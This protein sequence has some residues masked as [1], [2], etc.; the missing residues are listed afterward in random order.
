MHAR[1]AHMPHSPGRASLALRRAP[2]DLRRCR[3]HTRTCVTASCMAMEL[4]STVCMSGDAAP[5]GPPAAAARAAFC[6]A[7]QSTSS[8]SHSPTAPAAAALLLLLL[9]AVLAAAAGPFDGPGGGGLADLEEG[10]LAAPPLLLLLLLLLLVLLL[11]GADVDATPPRP[12]EGAAV[13][14]PA[15][16]WA[17]GSAAGAAG[18]DGPA[19]SAGLV[20]ADDELLGAGAAGAGAACTNSAGIAA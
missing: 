20:V 6:C 10:L 17:A 15:F 14:A 7:T 3:P 9:L 19:A 13:A 1:H 4:L 16:C 12:V 5:P 8:T 2:L 11:L 18:L